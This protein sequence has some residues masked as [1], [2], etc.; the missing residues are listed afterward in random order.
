[1]GKFNLERKRSIG[2]FICE[3]HSTS[4]AAEEFGMTISSI[5]KQIN[6]LIQSCPR[7][8]KIKNKCYLTLKRSINQ[9]I[10]IEEARSFFKVSRKDLN[11]F[12]EDNI[13]LYCKAK[14]VEVKIK[15]GKM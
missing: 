12:V 1:M 2:N 15:T 11:S 9:G 6:T 4:E 10:T 5:N 3:G 13:A 8:V 14:F 7:Y